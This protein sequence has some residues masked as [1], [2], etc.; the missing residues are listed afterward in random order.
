[1]NNHHA[2]FWSASP[3]PQENRYRITHHNRTKRRGNGQQQQHQ[4]EKEQRHQQHEQQQR[5]QDY[6]TWEQNL[7]YTT[8]EEIDRWAVD[9][10]RVPEPAWDSLEQCEAGY[11]RMELEKQGRRR[12]RKPESQPQK[13]IGGG[14]QGVWRSQVGEPTPTSCAYRRVRGTG[15]ALCYAVECTVSPVRVHSPVRYIPAPRIG[16]ARVGIEPGKV[17]ACSVLKSSSVLA[18]SGLSSA[19]YTQQPS[20]GGSPLHQASCACPETSTSCFSSPH[21]P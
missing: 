14:T 16:R 9:P 20:S 19:T 17:G 2:A 6:A 21:S 10:G 12:G 1:M 11:W 8:W 18:R 3:S 15:Q 7:D 4:H 13:C 5:D